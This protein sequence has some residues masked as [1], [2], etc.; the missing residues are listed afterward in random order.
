MKAVEKVKKHK[1]LEALDYVPI[2]AL[3]VV[4]IIIVKYRYLML[5][6]TAYGEILKQYAQFS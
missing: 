5:C 3:K 2:E 4:R 6:F 1:C